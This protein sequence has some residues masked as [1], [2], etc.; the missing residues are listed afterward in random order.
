MHALD[1]DRL[2][3]HCA[4]LVGHH[5]RGATA[6]HAEAHVLGGVLVG[7]KLQGRP[8]RWLLRFVEQMQCILTAD[9][10]G[11]HLL[12]AS[13]V[14]LRTIPQLHFLQ[15]PCCLPGSGCLALVLVACSSLISERIHWLLVHSIHISKIGCVHSWSCSACTSWWLLVVDQAHGILHHRVHR[16][17]HWHGLHRSLA[18]VSLSGLL[19]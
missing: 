15:R 19:S 3:D 17:L 18:L 2:L 5:F 7:Q 13:A 8:C 4:T 1:V 6:D 11:G 10:S 12:I 14:S 9:I 16:Q